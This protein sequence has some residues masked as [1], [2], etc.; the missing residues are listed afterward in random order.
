MFLFSLSS[1]T[2]A[3]TS[4]FASNFLQVVGLSAH[5]RPTWR[6]SETSDLKGQSGLS[7]PLDSSVLGIY[8]SLFIKTVEMRR[9]FNT[10]GIQ[11]HIQNNNNKN[12]TQ[13]ILTKRDK[14]K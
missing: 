10:C 8:Y 7:A 3:Q 9:Q 2:Q 13:G 14:N 12:T 1:S 4:L 5:V 6:K 11:K